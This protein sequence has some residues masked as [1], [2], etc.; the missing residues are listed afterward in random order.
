M[1]GGLSLKVV[2][3]YYITDEVRR[4]LKEIA[5]KNNRDLSA[6]ISQLIEDEHRRLFDNANTTK[7]RA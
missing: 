6:T 5:T 4:K 3:R 1:K 7:A 2:G